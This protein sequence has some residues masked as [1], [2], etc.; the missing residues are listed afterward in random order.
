[1]IL[2]LQKKETVGE[3]DHSNSLESFSLLIKKLGFLINT[4]LKHKA[5][6]IEAVSSRY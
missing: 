2:I 6:I 1:M 3:M 4:F 5:Y